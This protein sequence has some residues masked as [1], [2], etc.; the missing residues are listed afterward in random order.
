MRLWMSDEIES[1]DAVC[2]RGDIGQGVNHGTNYERGRQ[3]R[4]GK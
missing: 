1:C 4:G 2:V 3:L